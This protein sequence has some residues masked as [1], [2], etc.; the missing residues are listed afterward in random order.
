MY[1]RILKFQPDQNGFLEWV[2]N[3]KLGIKIILLYILLL[4]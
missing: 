2:Q 4:L 1:I 3:P